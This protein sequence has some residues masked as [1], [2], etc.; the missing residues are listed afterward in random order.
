MSPAFRLALVA[1]VI[2]SSGCT[3]WRHMR[4]MPSPREGS[5]SLESV[6]LTPRETGIMMVLHDVQIT[7][8]SVIGWQSWKEGLRSR[9]R[10]AVHRSQ[11]LV[12]DSRGP[13]RWGTAAMAILAILAVGAA[14]ALYVLS[15]AL[16]S[17]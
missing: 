2:A 10:V 9:T 5:V 6:R 8:D 7:Q 14:A 13:N 17:A 1:V 16:A 12:L 4:T 15:L 11:V 3:Q